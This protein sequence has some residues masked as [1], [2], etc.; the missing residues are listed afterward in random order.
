MKLS[1]YP[2]IHQMYHREVHRMKGHQ[3]VIQEKIDGSQIS[4]GRKDGK[5][6]VRSKNQMIDIENPNGMFAPAVDILRDRT[7]PDG[8][9]FR[10]EYLKTPKHNVLNYDRIP[11]DH[12]IIYDIEF[13]DGSNHYLDITAMSEMAT[14]YEFEVVPT[15]WVGLF[16]DIDQ[17]LIDELMKNT[18]ILGGQLIE[19]LVFKCYD[20]FDSRDKTLM[21]KFVRPEVREMIS[22]KRGK[23]RRDIIEEIGE[24]LATPARFEKGVQHL[25]DSNML[26]DEPKDIG[27]LMRELNRD[28]EEHV[29]EIK[30]LLYTNFRKDIIRVANRG[31]AEWYK[32]KL[33][34]AR[35]DY[36][37]NATPEE[38]EELI[39]GIKQGNIKLETTDEQE[40]QPKTD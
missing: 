23:T 37:S 13:H 34:E 21:C 5:L 19:G 30:N 3:V 20:V 18:S 7:L 17:E 35:N 2:K 36:H 4:S 31:F 10:G 22:G 6:F 38:V 12:I 27:V 1:D 11:K 9:V 25:R 28:F 29:D 26:V 40:D 16:D 24:R 15:L 14:A 33:I 32:A 8:Y 39:D